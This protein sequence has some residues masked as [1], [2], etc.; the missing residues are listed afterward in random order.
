MNKS[1]VIISISFLLISIAC[2]I[3]ISTCTPST[4]YTDGTWI[5]TGTGLK[6]TITVEVTTQDN[7]IISGKVTDISESDFA[8][9]AADEILKQAISK[10]S[11]NSIDAVSGATYTSK[12]TIEAIQNA[13]NQAKGKKSEVS[14]AYK[15]TQCDIVIIG[16]GGAGLS[17]AVE[18]RNNGKS[19]I[20]LEKMPIVGGNTNYAT[21]GL[22]ASETS[23]Q[24]RLGIE[25]SNEQY[26]QDTMVGGKFLNNPELVRTMV[27]NSAN[28]VDWLLGIG[29][30]LNDVGKMAGSTNKRTHRPTG[31]AA[32][33]SHLVGVLEEQAKRLG[34]DIR[35][36]NDVTKIINDNGK[37]CGV[38]VK[39]DKGNYK[40]KSKAVIIATGGFGAN[41]EIVTS[42]KKD[43]AGFGTTNHAGATGDALTWVKDFDVALVDMDQ[44]QTHPTV[45]PVK[46]LMITEAVR[47]NGAIMI[48]R[49]GKRFCSEMA[50]RDV[51]SSAILAQKGKTAYLVFD[52]SVR[53]SLKAIESYY[54]QGLLT[55]GNTTQELAQKL[56]IDPTVFTNT[57]DTYNKFVKSGVDSDFERKNSE[58]PRQLNKAPFYAVEVGPAI[59]HTMGGLKI[60]TKT[61]VI[62]NSGNVVPGLFAAGEVTGGVHGANRL[63][64]N[65]VADIAVF[66][67]IAGA[68]ASKL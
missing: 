50:T 17:A 32:V 23:V 18:A 55:E 16:A 7:K 54:N 30:D 52:Q 63:G 57:I 39:T 61:Q 56:N 44:I 41:P 14:K 37:A 3:G 28:T 49:D 15:D 1:K 6:G 8:I 27:N 42:Y 31:G 5:G 51:M 65:A 29:A 60:N 36:N 22:N 35:L 58:M 40:I 66:G 26:Y 45:V 21:G 62:D 13:L 67:K 10:N 20:V 9:P 64:G 43:L 59:H 46:N 53:E 38:M 68:E 4:S 11:T 24:K 19:V 12:G 48:N 25:D 33:G 2:I 47:G 34:A